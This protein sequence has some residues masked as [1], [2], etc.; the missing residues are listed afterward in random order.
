MN[1]TSRHAFA[2]K[3]GD[4]LARL[5]L[6]QAN[7]WKEIEFTA[8]H[9]ADDLRVKDGQTRMLACLLVRRSE[10]FMCIQSNS[11]QPWEGPSSRKHSPLC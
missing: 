3:L 8:Q 4:L 7:Q 10:T 2:S 9:L 5:P 6:N 11:R 1:G